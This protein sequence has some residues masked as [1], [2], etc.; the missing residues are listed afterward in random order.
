MI[1]PIMQAR[2]CKEVLENKRSD[3]GALYPEVLGQKTVAALR[4]K[5]LKSAAILDVACSGIFV[6]VGIHPHTAFLGN[7]VKLDEIGFILTNDDMETSVGGVF[8]AGDCRQKTLTQV[9]TA[10]ADGAIA[11]F[12]ANRYLETKE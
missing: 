9:I 5:N 1:P 2:Y 11:A 7:L 4:I 12:N 8:A 3:L 10:C 6:F